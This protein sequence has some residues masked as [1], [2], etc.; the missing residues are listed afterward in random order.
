MQVR[1][2]LVALLSCGILAGCTCEC[3]N[4]EQNKALVRKTADILNS[5]QYDDLDSVIAQ[6]YRRYCQATPDVVVES[7]DEFKALLRQWDREVPD[8]HVEMH[9]MAAEGDLVA[10]WGTYSGTQEGPMGPFPAT[11]KKLSADFGGFFRIEEGMI[12]ETWVTW[13]NLAILSQL[14]HY[15]PPQEPSEEGEAG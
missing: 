8:G 6:D 9:K 14:G 15:P 12:V 5:H 7:L 13:D 4:A 11:G 2:A 10:V 1:V 3:D